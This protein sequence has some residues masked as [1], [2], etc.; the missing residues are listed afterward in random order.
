MKKSAIS[1]HSPIHSF[2]PLLFVFLILA[3][4]LPTVSFAAP[5]QSDYCY[6]PPFVTDPN[7]TPNVMFVYEKGTAI[8]KRAYSTTYT[9]DAANP[10]YGFFDSRDSNLNLIYYKFAVDGN[11]AFSPNN[12]FEKSSTC[13]T[14]AVPARYKCIPGDILN[15]A[16]MTSLDLSRKVL[17]GFGWPKAVASQGAGDVYTYSGNFCSAWSGTTCTT[18]T[19]TPISYGQFEDGNND[20]TVTVSVDTDGN[21]TN[22]YTYRFCI[23]KGNPEATVTVNG[24]AGLVAPSCPNPNTANK[25][26]LTGTCL[27][28]GTVAMKFTDEDRKGLIQQYADKNSDYVY[29]SDAPRFGLRRWKTG[30]AADDRDRDI[31][32]DS[33]SG[34]CTSTTKTTLLKEYLNAFSKDPAIDPDTPALGTMMKDIVTYFK[35][36][37]STYEDKDSTYTQ[38]PYKWSTDPAKNC[39]KTFAIFVTTGGDLG[40]A[41]DALDV[42][43]VTPNCDSLTYT[44]S[45]VKNTCYG[46]K[47]DL[48]TTDSFKQNIRTYVVH[49][50]FYGSGSGNAAKLTYAAKTVGGGEYLSVD[51]PAKLKSKIEEALLSI[52]STSASASTV[53][54]LTTQTRESSTLTQAYFYP[55]REN[56]SLRWLGY[57]RLLWSDSGANLREDTLNTGWL[58]L[59]K[60]NILS[61]YYDPDL[62]AYKGRTFTVANTSPYLTI[63]TCDPSETSKV[64]T[65]LNDN[66]FA[67][68]N[69][70]DKLLAMSPSDRNIKIGIGNTAGVVSGSN[71]TTTSGSGC[72]NF[73][74]DLKSTLQPFWNYTG[75]CSN[76]PTTSRWCAQTSDCYYCDTLR[77]NGV[78]R[79]CSSSGSDCYYCDDRKTRKCSTDMTCIKTAGPGAPAVGDS[80]TPTVACATV[81]NACTDGTD[82]GVCVGDCYTYNGTCTAET[83]TKCSLNTSIS[84]TPATEVA[85]CIGDY[86]GST[87]GSGCV[88]AAGSTICT[89]SGVTCNADCDTDNCAYQVIRFALG[90]DYPKNSIGAGEV[91][92]PGSGFRVRS[93]CT[94]DGDCPGGTC[95]DKKCRATG[96]TCS[97]DANCTSVNPGDA[98]VG[99]CSSA[100]YDVTKTLKL[101][102]IVYST[103]RIS[104]NSAVNGYDV[105]YKDSTY[106]N[107]VGSTTIKNAMPIV[108]VGANDGMVHA[109]Q[110]SKI[111]DLSPA[112][113]NCYGD[114][115]CNDKGTV[116]D[117]SQTARF[118]DD[119]PTSDSAPP[120]N[121]GKELWAYIPFNA[122]PYLRWYCDESYCH[123]PMVDAR[124]TVVDASIDYDK[125]G[126]VDAGDTDA[127][128]TDVR[129]CDADGTNC[130]WRRLLIGAMGIGGRQ[131][132]VGSNTWSSSVFVLDITDTT[133]P[134]LLWE[135][136]LPDNT[137]TAG[138]PAVVRLSSK[139][140]G[141]D[142]ITDTEN[143]SW[144]VVF[145]SGPT[146]VGTNTV[147]YKSSN[148][149]IHVFN[150]RTGSEIVSGGLDIGASGVAVGDM[151][152]VDMDS[153][154][155]VDDIYFGTYGGSGASQTGKFYRLRIREGSSYDS[156]A[157][158]NIETVVD[159]GRPIFASPEIAQDS[160]GNKWLYF[161]TG[162]YLSLD[163]VTPT[164]YCSGTTTAC[165]SNSDCT[166]PATCV[167]ETG[168]LEYLYGVK[169][170]DACWKSGGASCT[171]STPSAYF[172]DTTNISFTGAKAIEAG[173]FC[174]G[175]LMSTIS[176]DSDGN[177]TGSCG[178]NKVCRNNTSQ[179][180]SLDSQCP[181]GGTCIENKV[182]LKVNNATISGSGVP[183]TS[184]YNCTGKV[185]TDA[186]TCIENNISASGFNG[187]DGN[188]KACKGWRREIK[189]QKSFSKPF[190]A[191]GLVDYTTYQP[192]TTVCSL[193]GNAHLLSLH[194]TT[195]TA[196]VQPTI[197]SQ[198]GTSG[199]TT[200]LTISASVNLGI[201]VPPLGESLVALP[202]AGD[203]FKVI[204]QVSGGLPGTSMA[205]SLPAKSGYVLWIVK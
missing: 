188:T 97:S 201:G 170:P 31:L 81:G 153:D 203:T 77:T 91:A 42:T 29:D 38:T 136:P 45:F 33:T 165:T 32:C 26:K 85:D 53:A 46:Y 147:T 23:S 126:A 43:E 101:G 132:T 8:A 144:Y 175:Q 192:T 184:P 62:V 142:P 160:S 149:K 67:I 79:A 173:C 172:L 135:R 60:D 199:S 27:G 39:R 105:T 185:D 24:Q 94:A 47:K 59:K 56:T 5:Q 1:T 10:Y 183:T 68:W 166:S 66:I 129:T 151:M 128:A 70:Q 164:A 178:T 65:K 21:G 15:W 174:A 72:Y 41:G 161:G 200:S 49:T 107:F 148:A 22:D 71:C 95:G 194:Y 152:A 75:T 114:A 86:H 125:S 187:C 48:Y 186:I 57:L 162:L 109:F 145:G 176:C 9:S 139:T 196:Y 113:D 143:G 127:K 179:S 58:D 6:L 80:I 108:I 34:N 138:T 25:C 14:D 106:K 84:C 198:G 87:G 16:L 115:S 167:A 63:D 99:N 11:K 182:V 96:V 20:T 163:D 83:N 103:P 190:V 123:I 134:K 74:T 155:Q 202:L 118:S 3:L 116:T 120:S 102:D 54:T 61:F 204:T 111:K 193:G 122:V 119:P 159:A 50:T 158:W 177:C 140:A 28:A 195:G 17:V 137:L 40:A 89:T 121:I 82:T 2:T 90:Y 35:G 205:P 104:P 171:Y 13:S 19:S 69:A 7:T 37:T 169:E 168:K 112:E 133:S 76:P 18:Q 52:I 98:C 124:F 51:N 150:L 146:A 191:G 181:S 64:T 93:Q 78:D 73:T 36:N 100:S 189:G 157:S 92:S 117:G 197:F 156:P 180:C 154:Y 110:V 4:L 141:G 88:T 55:K 44:D 30:T 130:V 12:Y 131:I